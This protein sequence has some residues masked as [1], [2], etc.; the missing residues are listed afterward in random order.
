MQKR[1]FA[2]AVSNAVSGLYI[3]PGLFFLVFRKKKL[4]RKRIEKSASWLEHVLGSV[5]YKLR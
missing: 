1:A 4:P 5:E 2:L 3:A